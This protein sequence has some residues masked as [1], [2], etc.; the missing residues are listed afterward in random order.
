MYGIF[1][2]VRVNMIKKLKGWS[3]IESTMMQI[4]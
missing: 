3:F 4:Y 1:A 2:Y